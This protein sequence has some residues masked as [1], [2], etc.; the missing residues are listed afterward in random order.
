MKDELTGRNLT[1]DQGD[2]KI[3]KK[4]YPS[5]EIGKQEHEEILFL[6]AARLPRYRKGRTKSKGERGS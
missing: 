4:S 5:R 3:P 6:L 1:L 2:G